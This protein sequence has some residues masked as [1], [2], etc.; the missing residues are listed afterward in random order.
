MTRTIYERLEANLDYPGYEL[1]GFL[2]LKP[3]EWPHDELRK[4]CWT[5]TGPVTQPVP[6]RSAVKIDTRGYQYLQITVPKPLLI[7][8]GKRYNSV[9]RFMMKFY[10]DLEHHHQVWPY[11]LACKNNLCV[12]PHHYYMKITTPRSSL[13]P[14]TPT[15]PLSEDVYDLIDLLTDYYPYKGPAEEFATL[16]ALQG[17]IAPI[18]PDYTTEEFHQAITARFPKW[19]PLL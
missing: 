15:E 2:H 5:W 14:K 7:Y 12:N 11:N 10:R 9:P 4:E 19:K 3:N 17:A 6:R 1:K 8:K 18:C 16:A 13:K